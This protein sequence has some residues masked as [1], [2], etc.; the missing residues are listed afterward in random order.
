MLALEFAHHRVL[1][2]TE[3]RLRR[4][5]VEDLLA[6]TDDESACLRAEALGHN[7]RVPNTVTILHW[8]RGVS[9]D[10]IATAARRMGY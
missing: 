2:E 5:L 7:L 6:G 4:D 8:Q 9:G 10:V 1:A 3:L